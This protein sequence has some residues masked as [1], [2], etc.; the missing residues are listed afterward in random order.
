MIV[1]EFRK[2]IN[3]D[4]IIVS[5]N[6]FTECPICNLKLKR[7]YSK[8]ELNV[9]EDDFMVSPSKFNLKGDL[10]EYSNAHG[11]EEIIAFKEH[12]TNFGILD[13]NRIVEMLNL[14]KNRY[15]HLSLGDSIKSILVFSDTRFHF[16]FDIVALPF[17]PIK[18]AEEM[19]NS[20]DYFAKLMNS[21]MK[22]YSDENIVIAVNPTPSSN[23][24]LII[25]PKRRVP[26]ITRLR[27]DE[28][29]SLAES[30]KISHKIFSS[31]GINDYEV[32]FYN[33]PIGYDMH[34]HI[35]FK[36]IEVHN[37]LRDYGIDLIN[38]VPEKLVGGMNG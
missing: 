6:K 38:E 16:S 7:I 1:N 24:E 28:I 5:N 8:G 4:W 17:I 36:N 19:K 18:I 31:N 20:N 37:T 26:D 10:Y 35:Y 27:E 15:S 9:F 21:N 34:F 30:F 25:L 22:L 23:Y 12:K 11:W 29:H 32:L 13:T 2:S 3:G 14:V 33:S